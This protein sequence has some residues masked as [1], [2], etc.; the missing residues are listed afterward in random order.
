MDILGLWDLCYSEG[1]EMLEAIHGFQ[2]NAGLNERSN[3]SPGVKLCA[4]MCQVWPFHS[5]EAE[6]PQCGGRVV[7]YDVT[8]ELDGNKYS[9]SLSP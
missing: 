6:K 1:Y 5:G 3:S 2:S 7:I 4:M 8:C 9:R